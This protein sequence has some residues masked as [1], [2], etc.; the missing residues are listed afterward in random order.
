VRGPVTVEQLVA[1]TQ[2][3]ETLKSFSI[4]IFID[5][6]DSEHDFYGIRGQ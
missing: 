1:W 3:E 5:G 6:K 4:E 2:F